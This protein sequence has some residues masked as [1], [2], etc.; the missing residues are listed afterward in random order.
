MSGTRRMSRRKLD[1]G[2]HRFLQ[3][4]SDRAHIEALLAELPGEAIGLAALSP[5]T[6]L[7]F[8]R[9]RLNKVSHDDSQ[10]GARRKEAI[11]DLVAS[12]VPLDP[13]TRSLI[14]AELRRLYFPNPERDRRAKR[15]MRAASVELYKQQMRRYGLTAAEAEHEIA[16]ALGFKTVGALR[17]HLL[18]SKIVGQKTE[19]VSC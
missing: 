19:K 10:F 5:S 3:E 2:R 6:A 18:R 9:R 11:I 14:A 12:D 7:D 15:Q 13:R 16:A 4:Q 8:M 1:A 17:K